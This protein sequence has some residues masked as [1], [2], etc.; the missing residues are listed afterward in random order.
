MKI[1]LLHGGGFVPRNGNPVDEVRRM[2]G[3]FV[4]RCEQE[5]FEVVIPRSRYSDNSW[6]AGNRACG[7]AAKERSPDW[8][9]VIANAPV[10]AGDSCCVVGI[11]NGGMLALRI[12]YEF[13]H[14][15][16]AVCSIAGPLMFDVKPFGKAVFPPL[17][18]YHGAADKIVPAGGG[19]LR[20]N[21]SVILTSFG[22]TLRWWSSLGPRLPDR[23]R[24]DDSSLRYCFGRN[25][26][27]VLKHGGHTWPGGVDTRKGKLGPVADYPANAEIVSFFK[28]F[29]GGAS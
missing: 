27:V 25:R 6:H 29:A 17:L 9:H 4:E 23:I 15:V 21:P 28:T 14:L 10:E 24:E 18:Y 12:A 16:K 3:D 11:S 7:M 13:P 2:S 26:A 8:E 20:S 1:I 19:L 5:G 22:N